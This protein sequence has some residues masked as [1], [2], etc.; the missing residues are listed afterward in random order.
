MNS[1]S[2]ILGAGLLGLGVAAA[3]YFVSNTTLNERTGANTAQVKGLSERIVPADVG[4]WNLH[5][6][7]TG[8][9][10]NAVGATFEIAETNAARIREILTDA[11]FTPDEFAF[12]PLRK[13]DYT[14]RDHQG[15]V[16][17]QYFTVGGSVRISTNS[18]E[19][20]APARG[21]VFM[22]ATEGI[23]VSE[24]GIEY[25]FTK[26]NDI[27]PDML[28]EA[29]ENARIAANEFAANAGVSVGGIQNASQGGFQIRTVN[30]STSELNKLVRV[31]TNITFYLEN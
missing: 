21:P 7:S 18:P 26:L 16:T 15:N 30:N 13:S 24:N 5:Y 23:D 4:T 6:A 10:Y 29:T 12:A 31:V 25:E 8:F 11:G 2:T 27:K 17:R 22:L 20:I 9:D 28:R 3:G 1:I 14:E 19:K